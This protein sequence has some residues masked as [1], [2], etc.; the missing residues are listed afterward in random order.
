MT[1]RCGHRPGVAELQADTPRPRRAPPRPAAPGRDAPRA[2][3]RSRFGAP[4]PS[5]GHRAVR[6]RRHARRRRWPPRRWKSISS[7]VTTCPRRHALERRRLDDRVA[8]RHRP[9]TSRSEHLRR[10]RR[11]KPPLCQPDRMVDHPTNRRSG[12]GRGERHFRRRRRACEREA[13]PS[14]SSCPHDDLRRVAKVPL[15]YWT[16]GDKAHWI[17]IIP[18][19]VT[20][21]RIWSRPRRM[22]RSGRRRRG[23]RRRGPRRESRTQRGGAP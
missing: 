4:R 6:E 17:R 7:S 21:R 19:Q 2:G 18:D 11:H 15:H 14:S 12:G 5:V 22:P 23:P 1:G 3:P 20:G 8:Q 10:C 16:L 13:S 9:H